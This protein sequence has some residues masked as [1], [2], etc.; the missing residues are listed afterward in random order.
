MKLESIALAL[1]FTL[2][3]SLACAQGGGGGSSGD[4]ANAP[5]FRPGATTGL[6]TPSPGSS[7]NGEGRKTPSAAPGTNSFGA[8][9]SSGA[10]SGNG[11][12]RSNGTRMPGPN[13]PTRTSTQDSD[14]KIATETR[15]LND[16]VKSICRGC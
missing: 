1:A 9:E 3:S 6:A 4:A 15:R 5:G 16:A 7:S 2:A 13:A 8:T 11:A 12:L 14:T 10:R